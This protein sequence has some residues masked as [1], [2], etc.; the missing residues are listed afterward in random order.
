MAEVGIR[1]LKQNASAVVAE[2]VAGEVITITDRGH[3]VAMMV[4]VISG[5]IEA[6]LAAAKARPALRKLGDLPSPAARRRGRPLI[7]EVLDEMRE[8]E[9][10]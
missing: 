9:R 2:V 1:A 10:Y 5:R 6:L 7:S 4:P 3:R 8:A